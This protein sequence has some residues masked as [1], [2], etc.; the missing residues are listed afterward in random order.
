[1]EKSCDVILKRADHKKRLHSGGGCPVRT[2]FR[3]RGRRVLQMQTSAV[4]G[5]KT[6]EFLKFMDKGEGQFFYDFVRT[7]FMDGS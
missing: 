4:F 5:A 1:M 7:F 3:Q 2:F 6:S